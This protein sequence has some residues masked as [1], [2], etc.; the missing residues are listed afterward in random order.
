MTPLGA[1]PA[2]PEAD[3]N[4]AQPWTF[5]DEQQLFG[6]VR[7]EMDFS[8]VVTGWLAVGARDGEEANVLANPSAGG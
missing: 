4:Y 3:V 2:V 6:V 1:I 8:D 7:A 5:T